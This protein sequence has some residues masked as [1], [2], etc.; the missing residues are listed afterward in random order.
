[1]RAHANFAENAP[2]FLILLAALEIS[3][4]NPQFL[5]IVSFAFVLARV[6]HGLGMDGG[7]L[8]RL[9]MVGMMTNTLM[10]ALLAGYAITIAWARP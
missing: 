3:G 7:S 6:A 10:I 9:R 4:G 5:L 8:V 1:M 2:I